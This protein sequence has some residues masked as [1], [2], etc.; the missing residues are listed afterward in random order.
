MRG[1]IAA[2]FTT[3][4]EIRR[5][6]FFYRA[7]YANLIGSLFLA[8]FARLGVVDPGQ[9]RCFFIYDGGIVHV[10]AGEFG[11]GELGLEGEG[12]GEEEE[13]GGD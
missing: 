5:P 13:D 8:S 7:R 1:R 9:M 10:F 3:V 12:D 2:Y 11:H 4:P 6:E